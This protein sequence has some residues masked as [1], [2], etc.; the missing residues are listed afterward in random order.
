MSALKFVVNTLQILKAFFKLILFWVNLIAT[1]NK[2]PM[3]EEKSSIKDNKVAGIAEGETSIFTQK[4]NLMRQNSNTNAWEDKG[5]GQVNVWKY[6]FK[7]LITAQ[8]V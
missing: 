2:P 7:F 5:S 3:S 8:S 1:T 6:I 4:A